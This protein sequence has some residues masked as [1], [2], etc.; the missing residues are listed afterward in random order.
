[1]AT[2][3]AWA[4]RQA[5]VA[6]SFGLACAAA[7][8]CEANCDELSRERRE[9]WHLNVGGVSSHSHETGANGHRWSETHPGVGIEQRLSGLPWS[10][11]F[12]GD[13]WRTS[14]ALSIFADSRKF[15][16]FSAGA[17]LTHRV[18][19]T[20]QARIDAGAGVFLF[21]RSAS[22]NGRMHWVPALLPMLTVSDLRSPWGANLLLRPLGSGEK[23]AP[24]TIY[25]QVTY[26]ISP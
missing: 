7:S 17:S 2:L 11:T 25:V 23:S 14:Y 4:A 13:P 10:Y 20:D 12:E 1:M 22:W 19:Q 24:G 9:E 21:Y 6:F 26:R 5:A 8:A 3:F 16:T 15:W 18:S